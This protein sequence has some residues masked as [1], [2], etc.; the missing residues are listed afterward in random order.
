MKRIGG[1]LVFL[2]LGA[3]MSAQTY[4][5]LALRA[6]EAARGDSLERAEYLLKK[7]LE[8]DPS[9]PLNAMLFANLGTV[10]RRLGKSDEAIDAYSLALNSLPLSVPVL[11]DRASLYLEKNSYEKAYID[12]C[13][14]LDVDRKNE[15]ALLY[16]AYIYATR[17]NYKEARIDYNTLLQKNPDHK[18]GR[19]GLAV[20]NQKEGRLHEALEE[21]NQLITSYSNDIALLKARANLELEMNTPAMALLDVESV[22]K[23]DRKDADAYLLLGDILL[24][25]K[26]KKDAYAA[27][28]KAVTFG[29]PR[30]EIQDRLKASR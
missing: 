26:R 10:E 24:R 30:P 4:R 27:F 15:E 7:A 17:R 6:I 19:M 16:R 3:S 29:I 8:T 28:E 5:E 21:F 9:N 14:V 18:M 1:I 2:F 20:L 23:I 13:N 22:L 25:L 11:L 12:Y